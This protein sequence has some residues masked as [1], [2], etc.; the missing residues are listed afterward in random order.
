MFLKYQLDWIKIVDS[1]LMAKFL[2]IANNFGTPS[3]SDKDEG[4]LS[5]EKKSGNPRF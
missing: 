5:V 4:W 3:K 1:V 2:A